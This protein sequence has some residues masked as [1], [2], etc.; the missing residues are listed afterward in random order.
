VGGA[1]VNFIGSGNTLSITNDLCAGRRCTMIGNNIRVLVTPGASLTLGSNPFPN[2]GQNG[3]TLT[4]SP[5]AAVISVSG[6]A[7]VKQGQ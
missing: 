1:L 5:D 7:Q 6:A 3:N 4:L 2:L